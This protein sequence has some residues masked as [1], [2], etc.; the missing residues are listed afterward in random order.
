MADVPKTNRDI[1]NKQRI[2]APQGPLAGFR[3]L[4]F[5]QVLASPYLGTMLSDMGAEVIKVEA[6]YGDSSRAYGPLKECE[7]GYY[8]T[9]N[10]GKYGLCMDL[11]HPK[12]IEICKE[13]TKICDICIENWRPGIMAKRGLSYADL[14]S[15]N[16]GII[17]ASVSGF[18]NF[19]RY[20]PAPGPYS[21]RVCY[22]VIAQA[23]SGHQWMNGFPDKAPHGLDVSWS[24][25]N[26]G[27][28]EAVAIVAALIQR[29]KTGRGQWID[30][31]L[32]DSMIASNENLICSVSMDADDVPSP[33]RNGLR[34]LS[35]S[36]YG[37]FKASDDYFVIGVDNDKRFARLC[38]AMGKPELARDPKFDTN[39]H[40]LQNRTE[41][42]GM[43][44]DWCAKKTVAECVEV[45][46]DQHSVPAGP[47]LTNT[48]YVDHPHYRERQ[49][50]VPIEQPRAGTFDMNGVVSKLSHTPG[51]VQGAAPLMG[52]HNRYVL[53]KHL[54]YS[55]KEVDKLYADLV[56]VD[57]LDMEYGYN[58]D[59][60]RAKA[61]ERGG[62]L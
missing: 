60:A 37:V 22:D 4:D 21:P 42:E 51:R 1:L 3:V 59:I 54:G 41:L 8:I 10:R 50:L 17:Y 26:T 40:R 2:F 34:R 9:Q 29:Q 47:I 7:A 49:M 13:L 15:V 23:E 12:A 25:L 28:H 24:D 19:D 55:D 62:E 57:N 35:L 20:A 39:Q 52:E 48:Q 33:V 43:V 38:E 46:R 31:A 14:R 11:T 58:V 44:E 6:S 18:G 30:I 53:K 61:K 16:P 27:T 56:V 32:T 45:L 36:P 5:S